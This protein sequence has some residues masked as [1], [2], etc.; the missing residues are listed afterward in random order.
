M[1]LAHDMK[2]NTQ[3]PPPSER[4]H[5]PFLEEDMPGEEVLV[6]RPLQSHMVPIISPRVQWLL[7]GV[8]TVGVLAFVAWMLLRTFPELGRLD[9]EGWRT[10]AAGVWQKAR[11][12]DR[13]WLPMVY[14]LIMLTTVGVRWLWL[15]HLT[16]R[17]GPQGL[18]QEHRLPLGLHHLFGQ[19]WQIDWGDVRRITARRSN[20]VGGAVP[21]LAWVEIVVAVGYGSQR[22][23][24][25]A[26]W[27][28]P[29][30][31]PRP[32]LKPSGSPSPLTDPWSGSI[33]QTRLAEAFAQ[34]RLVR[35]LEHH[36]PTACQ[37]LHWPGTAHPAGT[38]LNRQPEA[39][40]LLGGTI[41][42]F[43]TGWALMLYAPHVHL[44]ASPTWMD[45]AAWSLGP[46]ALWALAAWEWRR[47]PSAD[48]LPATPTAPSKG[49]D[50]VSKPAL[51]FA[52]VLW[53]AA[54]AFVTEPLLVHAAMLGRSGAWQTHRFAIAEGQAR[55][56]GADA[57]HVP[58]IELPGRQSRLAWIRAGSEADVQTVK[59]RWGVW[60]YNDEPL[61]ALADQQGVH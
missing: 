3:A 21:T 60:I 57:V 22:V 15:R 11:E 7:M 55:P 46:L 42:V 28:R 44:H 16:L 41:V 26:F 38:D 43:L 49:R 8:M 25:P 30:D 17:I 12:K 56:M 54:V 24:R 13:A 29:N 1:G 5:P 33:N 40:V 59:G 50:P 52:A 6:Y 32:H 36:A 9:P 45:R 58:P 37:A 18:R 27:F 61:R 20:L 39:L 2:Q 35:A 34:L 19:N 51:A 53:V 48:P 23:L 4:A 10:L 47:Q 31:P 14:P